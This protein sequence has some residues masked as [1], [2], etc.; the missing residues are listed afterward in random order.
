MATE[1]VQ[2]AVGNY[3]VTPDGVQSGVSGARRHRQADHRAHPA[4]PAAFT[5][6]QLAWLQARVGRYP[7]DLYGSLVVQADLGFALETQTLELIDTSLV[8]RL[9]PRRVGAD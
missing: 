2:L 7:F 4:G 9:R 1:L 5:G 3:D 6:P 8:R